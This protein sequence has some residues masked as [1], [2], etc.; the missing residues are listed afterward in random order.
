MSGFADF[1]HDKLDQDKIDEQALIDAKQEW[2][3]N[4][5]FVYSTIENWLS[6]SKES[7]IV[8][9]YSQVILEEERIGKYITKSMNIHLG[10]RTVIIK[11]EG[12]LYIGTKGS[13]EIS[14]PSKRIKYDLQLTNNHHLLKRTQNKDFEWKIF[15][16]P[17]TLENLKNFE[18][19]AFENI[20]KTLL[21]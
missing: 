16:L 12:C 2:L 7:G 18:K 15:S 3:E 1:C 21:K 10:E 4:I 20:L 14:S 19:N 6:D 8:I 13:F 17:M 5:D 11:P 9:D